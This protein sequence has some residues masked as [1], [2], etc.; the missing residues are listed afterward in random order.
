ML[1]HYRVTKPLKHFFVVVS[2]VD[3]G[4]SAGGVRVHVQDRGYILAVGDFSDRF[5][6]ADQGVEACAIWNAPDMKDDV[7]W[8]FNAAITSFQGRFHDVI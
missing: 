2:C 7:S 6:V 8:P 5:Q 1:A 3:S 4:C